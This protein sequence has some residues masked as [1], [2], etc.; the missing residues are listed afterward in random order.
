MTRPNQALQRTA[1]VGHAACVPQS[2]PRMHRARPP[3]SLSLGS[4]G[5]A[6]RIL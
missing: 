3:L 5:D 4:L 6:T 1:P 2:P